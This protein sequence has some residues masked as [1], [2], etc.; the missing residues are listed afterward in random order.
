MLKQSKHVIWVLQGAR[1]GDNAQA[2]ELASRLECQVFRKD[3]KF[4]LLHHLPNLFLGASTHSLKP[5]SKQDLLPPWPDLVIAAGKRSAPIA[6]WIKQQS[7]GHTKI[8]QLG[9]PR[10]P[11][12]AFDLVITTPQYG[13]PQ[14]D[15]VIETSLP[16]ATARNVVPGEKDFWRKEWAHLRNP[17]IAVAIGNAKFPLRMGWRETQLL[18]RH[19]NQLAEQT[20][21]SLLLIASPRTASGVIAQIAAE[22]SVP[23]ISYA[24]VDAGKN[25]YQS[26]LR[27]CDR[28]VVTSDSVSMISELINTGKPVDVFELPH[29]G[30]KLK[31]RA[32][33][34][35]GA[36]LSR[37]GILQPPRDVS[38]MVHGLIE[39]G[40]I[41]ILGEP[42]KRVPFTR[43][44]IAIMDRLNLL[45]NG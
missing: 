25:P 38:G 31:W 8:V 14:A 2:R 13:L 45:L 23:Y 36:W 28:F 7:R 15:N 24:K 26:A 4:N 29:G 35:F 34:G 33:A 9:R 44:D 30:V 40:Y 19:L 43:E 39:K 22:L 16:F 10:A 11:L 21:G 42:G 17:W 32:E 41:N 12:A 27:I 5:I 3:L 1:A 37:N 20:K 6:R 18:G